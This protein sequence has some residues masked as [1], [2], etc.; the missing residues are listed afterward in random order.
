VVASDIVPKPLGV[1]LFS[2]QESKPES[3]CID[4]WRV[5]H[6]LL[7]SRHGCFQQEAAGPLHRFDAG[8]REASDTI[9]RRRE[10]N[11]GTFMFSNVLYAI[12]KAGD[13]NAIPWCDGCFP[14]F[15]NGARVSTEYLEQVTGVTRQKMRKIYEGINE[16]AFLH[17]LS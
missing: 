2:I 12:I 1:L 13:E 16:T 7:V 8:C 11:A 10:G 6:Y 17:G 5:R 15:S 3:E 9:W 4:D 14:V